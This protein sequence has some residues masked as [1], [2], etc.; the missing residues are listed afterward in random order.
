MFA[1]TVREPTPEWE[2]TLVNNQPREASTPRRRRE[3]P[4]SPWS[5]SAGAQHFEFLV[6]LPPNCDDGSRGC[7]YLSP[8]TARRRLSMLRREK[9]APSSSACHRGDTTSRFS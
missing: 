9:E 3:L 2:A 1:T 5:V 6:A 7:T 8:D 4:A